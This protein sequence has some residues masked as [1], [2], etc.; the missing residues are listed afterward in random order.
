VAE[1]IDSTRIN[2]IKITQLSKEEIDE[3]QNDHTKS[4]TSNGNKTEKK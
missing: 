4:K 3:D 2:K 1:E